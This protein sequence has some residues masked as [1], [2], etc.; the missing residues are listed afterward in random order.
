[1]S[2]L[3]W[4]RILVVVSSVAGAA[5]WAAVTVAPTNDH[6]VR[7][8]LAGDSTVTTNAGW[9]TGFAHCLATNA[10]C[11]NLARGGRSSKSFIAEGRW[12]ECLDLKPDYVLI[13]FGHNDQPGKGA[14]RE[15]DL[16]TYRGFMTQYVEK[17]PLPDPATPLAR[18]IIECAKALY[19]LD[20]SPDGFPLQIKINQMVR[21][22]FGL[23]VEEVAW[24]RDLQLA[25]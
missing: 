21:E 6:H 20:G 7:I 23:P 4:P 8:V 16:P 10:E 2:A 12:K 18:E 13:Q 25:V 17:S 24:K 9:G 5:A 22:S 19:E 1:M 14:D 3:R 11:I 15:T